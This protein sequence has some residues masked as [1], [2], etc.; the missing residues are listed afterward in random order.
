MRAMSVGETV[1]S[2]S[3]LAPITRQGLIVDIALTATLVTFKS[4]NGANLSAATDN[5]RGAVCGWRAD[6]T[7]ARIMAE[8]MRAPLG[9]PR[10]SKREWRG[11]RHRRRPVWSRSHDALL[12]AT[13]RSSSAGHRASSP[14]IKLTH[15]PRPRVGPCALT[16]QDGIPLLQDATCA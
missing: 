15:C 12:Q 1:L 7:L 9:Q 10:L 11:R 13:F 6:D 8:R 4:G 5:H 16:G 14:L 3:V 2:Q